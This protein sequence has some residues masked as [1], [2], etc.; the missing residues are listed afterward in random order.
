MTATGIGIDIGGANLKSA[1]SDGTTLHRPF[2]LWR[3]PSRL[4]G[5][6]AALL[7]DLPAAD[8]VAVTMTGELCDCFPTKRHGVGAILEAVQTCTSADRVRVWSTAG[9]LL[10]CDAARDD[11]LA[12][13]AANWHALATFAGRMAPQG[14]AVLI[15]VGSTTTDIVP[16]LDGVPVAKGCTDIG[17][18]AS[19]ELV[20]TGVRRTPVCAVLGAEVMAEWF[21]TTQDAYLLLGKL[22]EAPGDRSTP[23]GRPA[24]RE[25]AHARLARTLG[26]D[27]ELV[28][29][30]DTRALAQRVERSQQDLIASAIRTVAGRLSSPPTAVILSGSGEFLARSA[31]ASSREDLAKPSGFGGEVT[32]QSFAAAYGPRASAAACAHALAALA[33]EQDDAWR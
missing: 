30:E 16:L 2:E 6:L 27:G 4:A 24:T 9:R 22:A 25:W 11:Y 26:G 32:L 1:H 3:D 5:E 14:S 21:A 7:R 31:W 15:D 13:A 28:P 12:V 17:R 23:D 8:R 20:Y 10:T 18:L 33:T 29:T 19:S